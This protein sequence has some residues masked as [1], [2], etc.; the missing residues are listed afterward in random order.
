MKSKITNLFYSNK[1]F[2]LDT[3]WL[4]ASQAVVIIS[5][6]LIIILITKYLG[7]IDLGYYNQLVSF[8]NILSI[9][10]ALG[11]NNTIIKNIA[12]KPDELDFIKSRFTNSL[13]MTIIQTIVFSGM[14]YVIISVF[15]Y[16]LSSKAL[17]ELF[18]IILLALPFYNINK[19]IDALCTGT[20]NQKKFSQNKI[21]RWTIMTII[22][23]FGCYLKDVKIVILSFTVS[24]FFLFVFNLKF[25]IQ[26]TS[27][28]IN[29]KIIYSNYKFGLS[30]YV[31]EMISV[32]IANID[33]I[34]LGYI[35][36]KYDIGL[37]GLMLSIARTLLIFP[38][39]LS[40]NLN[41]ITSKLWYE[42]KKEEL[43]LK[44]KKINKINFIVGILLFIF[45]L[46]SYWIFITFFKKEYSN[47]LNYFTIVLFGIF[48][49]STISWAGGTFIMI[50]KNKLN[51][52][53]TFVLSIISI[54]LTYFIA[55]NFGLFGA[56]IAILLNG[57][58]QYFVFVGLLLKL[59]NN[60]L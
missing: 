4:M 40:Q 42:N 3:I 52:I 6:F 38:G 2:A 60:K 48:I 24:E 33:I 5:G 27:L 20:R 37:Y 50:G 22:V 25:V 10:F 17:Q 9:I 1:K 31:A 51:N 36:S 57:I 7:L 12:E 59:K 46:I 58:I 28:N 35:L 29:K 26:N 56:S 23:W 30:T 54:T 15:P 49:I 53:R 39:I 41:P 32:V 14:F 47:S 55:L 44:L 11:I 21:V 13:L 19:N 16:L 8:Y 34:I 43:I 45:L 18:W